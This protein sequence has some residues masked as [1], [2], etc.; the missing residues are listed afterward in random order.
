[1][2][3]APATWRRVAALGVLALVAAG[4]VPEAATV[5]GREIQQLYTA[6]TLLAVLVGVFVA[7]LITISVLRFRRRRDD[8]SLPEQRRGHTGLEIVWTAIPAGIVAVLFAATLIVLSHVDSTSATPGVR[9]DV[10]AFRWGWTFS[11]ADDGVSVTGLGGP[12]EPGPVVVVPVGEPIQMTVRSNDVIH[13][14]AIPQF[15]FKRDVNPSWINTFQFTVERPGDYGGRC[16]EFCGVYH[17]AMPFTIRA[18][19]PG[20]YRAWLDQQKAAG[21]GAASA[22]PAAP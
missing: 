3:V 5:Q 21:A 12:G 16:A 10:T 14:L 1:V 9:M 8:D 19:D 20:E 4:C 6:V 11:Y 17:S 7:A 15:L 18:V 13:S 22:S 2:T